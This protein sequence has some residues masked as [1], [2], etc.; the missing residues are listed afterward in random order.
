MQ[1]NDSDV[2]VSEPPPWVPS[3]RN[4]FDFACLT[5]T[6]S[7][8]PH[9]WEEWLHSHNLGFLDTD[10]TAGPNLTSLLHQQ[11][12]LG[13]II[14]DILATTFVPKRNDQSKARRW[15]NVL[16]NKLNARLVAWHEALPNEMRWKKWLTA[17]DNLLPD[18]CMLQYGKPRV[19]P[20]SPMLTSCLREA[21]CITALAS[22]STSPFSSHPYSASPVPRLQSKA[23][24]SQAS[25]MS[26]GCATSPNRPKYASCPPR[27]SWR[28]FI[29][30]EPSIP[31]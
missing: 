21:L 30:S 29:A 12:E 25:L 9:A 16:L 5:L 27:A 14:H 6:C 18:I 24:G 20:R 1:D 15:T 4:I 22:V 28:S 26:P 13:R 23:A 8:D 2:D 17:K 19:R 10:R 7:D 3:P 11:V 31:W